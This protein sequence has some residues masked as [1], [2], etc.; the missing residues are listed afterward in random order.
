MP[1]RYLLRI[2]NAGSVTGSTSQPQ[3]RQ[4]IS[5]GSTKREN[6]VAF[7]IQTFNGKSRH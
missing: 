5:M 7:K 1:K 2:I 3:T 6:F 4:S